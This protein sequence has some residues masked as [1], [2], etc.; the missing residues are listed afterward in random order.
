MHRAKGR[1]VATAVLLGYFLGAVEVGYYSVDQ[2]LISIAADFVGNSTQG[3]V[4]PLF[5]RIK[6]DKARVAR[7]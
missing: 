1:F 5:S 3:T 6:N 4:L 7:G 2:R